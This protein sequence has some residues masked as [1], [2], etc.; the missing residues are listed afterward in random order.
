MSF[1]LN[2][3]LTPG[4]PST[5]SP[6]PWCPT[7]PPQGAGPPGCLL[8]RLVCLCLYFT[9][10][11]LGPSCRHPTKSDEFSE[12]FQTAVDIHPTSQNGPYLWKSCACI[13]YYPVLVPPCKYSTISIK[14]K[15]QH[16]FPKMRGG[17]KAVWDFSENSSDLVALYSLIFS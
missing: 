10:F 13:S 17:A 9:P 1:E 11:S 2:L 7:A 6:R 4:T 14:K 16:D 8:Y 12:R 3:F 15:L 5:C